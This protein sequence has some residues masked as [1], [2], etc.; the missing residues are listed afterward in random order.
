MAKAAKAI[1]KLAGDKHQK[2]SIERATM[3]PDAITTAVTRLGARPFIAEQGSQFQRAVAARR[4]AFRIS[5]PQGAAGGR[6]SSP[7]HQ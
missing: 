5:G 7:C 6:S 3:L 2:L 1:R 4:V